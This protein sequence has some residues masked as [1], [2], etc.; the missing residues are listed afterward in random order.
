MKVV[1]YNSYGGSEVLHINPDAP[2]PTL[3]DGQVLVEVYATSVNPFDD[4]LRLGYMKEMIPLTFPITI[5]GDFSGVVTEVSSGVSTF[6]VGDE[7]YGQVGGWGA[8]AE[9]IAVDP[10]KMAKKP[11]NLNFTEA[12]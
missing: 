6:S 4:K 9:Y 12:A 2:K 7:V 10:K 3:G 8:T 1:Q 5:G 11:K